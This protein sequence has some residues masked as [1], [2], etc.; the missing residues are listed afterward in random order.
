[1]P[2][3]TVRASGPTHSR[4]TKS[5]W[6]KPASRQ[7]RPSTTNGILSRYLAKRQHTVGAIV[8][9]K[10]LLGHLPETALEVGTI[11]VHPTIE[12]ITTQLRAELTDRVKVINTQSIVMRNKYCWA[13]VYHPD[14]SKGRGALALAEEAGI[15]RRNIVAVGDN[16]NDLDLF[17]AAGFSVAMGNAPTEVKA[18][19]DTVVPPVTESGAASFLEEIAAGRFPSGG[20]EQ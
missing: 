2:R 15:P 4:R 18:A 12:A 19:A 9:V 5:S 10:D 20:G 8:A 16:F 13:E 14:C 11:D 3:R 1:M 6:P 7:R 17:D